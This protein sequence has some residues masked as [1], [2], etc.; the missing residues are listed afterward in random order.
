M[1][2]TKIKILAHIIA[3]SLFIFG[4]TILHTVLST[5]LTHLEFLGMILTRVTVTDIGILLIAIAFFIE[6]F[7]TFRPISI[8]K[9]SD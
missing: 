3:I 5:Y 8:I 4:A 7:M 6:F 1:R 2:K 9:E